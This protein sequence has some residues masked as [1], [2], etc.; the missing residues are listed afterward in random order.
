M[1]RDLQPSFTGGEI[2]PSLHGRVDI[3]RY[4]SSLAEC[5]NFFVR[6][7]G[8]VERRAGYEFIA[9][10]AEGETYAVRAI[11]FIFG[12]SQAYVLLLT[13]GYIYFVTDGGLVLSSANSITG[14]TQANPCVVTSNSHGYSNGDEIYLSGIVG[15]T[16]LNSRYFKVSNSTASTFELEDM[17][18][19]TV[20]SSS[21]TAYVSDGDVAEVYKVATPYNESILWDIRFTQS[22]DVMTFTNELYDPY[23]LVRVGNNNWTMTA[24]SFATTATTPT[25]LQVNQIGE[26]SGS[27]GKHYRYVVTSVDE[28]G[29]ESV[30]SDIVSTGSLEAAVAVSGAT[31]ANPCVVTTAAPHGYNS[32][33]TVFLDGLGGMTELNGRF[34]RISTAAP[35]NFTLVG[36]DSTSYTAYTSGGTSQ[37][38]KAPIDALSDTYGNQISWVDVPDT[39]YYNIYKESSYNANIFGWIGETLGGDTLFSDYNF[40]PDMSITPPINYDPFDGVGNR[41]ECVTYHQQRLMFGRTQNAPQTVW[42]TKTGDYKNMDFSRPSRDDDSLEFTIAAQQVNDIQHLVSL[43][44][45]IV[46]TTGGEWRVQADADG[47]LTP[48]NINPRKQ[49]SRGSSNAR[50]IEIGSSVLYV[51]ERGSRVRDLQYRFEDDKYTGDDISIFASHLFDGYTIIDWTYAQEPYSMVWAVRSDGKLLSLSYLREH[52]VYGW[53]QH[54]TDGFVESVCSIPEGDENVVYIVVRRTISGTDY[55]FVERMSTLSFETVDDSFFIDSGLTYEGPTHT[56]TGATQANPVVITATAHGLET[57]DIIWIRGV[58]GMTELNDVQYSVVKIDANSYSLRDTLNQAIDGTAYAAYTSG[59][60]G[61]YCTNTITN[62]HHLE[63]ETVT[64][65]I[66][67]NAESGISVTNGS[68]TMSVAGNKV[69]IGL[70][71][72]SQIQT[73]PILLD[74]SMQS[75]KKNVKRVHMRVL[76]TRGLAAGATLNQM[77]DIKERTPDYNYGSIPLQTDVQRVEITGTWDNSGQIYVQQNYPLPA[78]I[79]QIIPE[80]TT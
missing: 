74:G 17:Y 75:R 61:Y 59:G 43:D 33:D 37:R 24:I 68:A 8:G 80:V 12:S 52:Q 34:F 55:R 15:M 63:G 62:L 44:D 40:G 77:E 69:S 49:S 5:K 20:D 45:L 54:D 7:H 30:Q 14:I 50:P 26:P 19:N 39:Q 73:L 65:L 42:G 35:G 72:S 36:V 58:E 60:T 27:T 13:A 46:F 78:T 6:A 2:A 10:I 25:G 18:G 3:S 1:A 79:L 48:S 67:G 51:Q 22:A 21:F 57:D 41:P 71:Y 29:S 70:P 56:I 11:P 76:N 31:Q 4:Q 28:S 16:E 32:G 53:S 9:N 38:E 47:V 64:A 23:E 66:D